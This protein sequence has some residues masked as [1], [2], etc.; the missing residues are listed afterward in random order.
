MAQVAASPTAGVTLRLVGSFGVAV[1]GRPLAPIEVGSRKARQL[2][3]ILAVRRGQ[4]QSV[5][6]LTELL[7]GDHPPRRPVDNLATLVSRL[8]AALGA[9]S[10]AGGR[11]GYRLGEVAVDLDEATALVRQAQRGLAAGQPGFAVVA[12]T[13]ALDL[14][15]DGTALVEEAYTDWAE[16]ARA[17]AAALTRQA[18][19]AG[20]EA[21]LATGDAAST[22]DFA[23]PALR[24]D[25]SDEIAARWV[26]RG[27][28]AAGQPSKALATYD[29]LRMVLTDE[30]G[31][32]PA[33]QTRTLH[34]AILREDAPKP[35]SP[36]G[37][38]TRPA[39]ADGLPPRPIS[40]QPPPEPTWPTAAQPSSRPSS[41][42]STPPSSR[43]SY[44]ASRP[45]SLAGRAGELDRLTNAWSDAAGGAGRTVLIAGEAGIGKTRLAME[46]LE[47]ARQ[48]GATILTARC[49]DAERSLFLQPFAELIARQVAIM[50]PDEVRAVLGDR[51]PALARLVPDVRRIAPAA[52]STADPEV[53]GAHADLQRRLV[54]EAV[55]SFL[56]GLTERVPA[57]LLIDDLHNAGFSSV[58]LLHYLARRLDSARLM[59]VATVRV[60]EGD[61][62]L[63]LLA[64][65]AERIDLGP[66]P[67]G[68]IARLAAEAGQAAMAE[69]I[70]RQT[71]GH[72]L[73]VVETLRGLSAGEQG[74]SRSL[75]AAVL[76]RLRPV[77]PAVEELLRTAAVVGATLDPAL[78]SRLLDQPSRVI[79][80]QCEEALAARLLVVAGRHYEF[81]N[82]LLREVL[83]ATTP[84][85]TRVAHHL[86]LTELL[87]DRPESVAEH[88]AAAG[89]WPRAGRAFLLAGEAALGSYS[90]RD[91]R[92]LLDRALTAAQRA[93][94]QLNA[95]AH[96]ELIGRIH[97][98]RGRALE[99]L[100][101]YAPALAEHRAALVAAQTAGD[102]RLE[103]TVL[104]ELAGDVP[105]ALGLPVEQFVS[106][107]HRGLR[108]AE[109][110]ADHG[111]AANLLARLAI[112]AANQL[113]LADAL[114]YGHRAV[115]A[116]RIAGTDRALA[117]GLDGLKTA[118]Y[119]LGDVS[120]LATV[121][122]ELEPI[123]RRQG[124]LYLLQWTVF[125]SALPAYAAGDWDTAAQ[126]MDLAIELN[127]APGTRRGGPGSW[128]TGRGWS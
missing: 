13:R 119:F 6:V 36:G 93:V 68:A 121:I 76:A 63:D 72:T 82:D 19:Y 83:Y 120:Q 26:M 2:L 116:G 69:Q 77:G 74:L 11:D 94:G 114:R 61:A 109:V 3:Q 10:I 113:R 84:E 45:V 85:P 15:G 20:A 122:E 7:W 49:Y 9:A 110:L 104:R 106:H 70:E 126:R 65:L 101:E 97:V 42:P 34:E 80:R 67:G 51:A 46:L 73:Y 124:D 87:E 39:P 25:G 23:A 27:H 44:P 24:S 48:L 66:L 117:A 38:A 118:C 64:G 1:D 71:R 52:T 88:A 18:R 62:A 112:I 17:E 103:M 56:R 53:E 47:Q 105:V 4:V 41:P 31:V 50:P 128:P 111:A 125:E 55:E 78:L 35:P 58:E 79:T 100:S 96:L 59:I 115:A 32:D 21:A 40:G 60:G 89:D 57:V 5:D 29:R 22:V 86:R 54:F 92:G 43:P 28:V 107:L 33:P 127:P 16:P 91:A 98:V 99:A 12:A 8:R 95:S 90:A 14:L 102:R 123:L 81:A 108:I 75:Q 37:P 30:L